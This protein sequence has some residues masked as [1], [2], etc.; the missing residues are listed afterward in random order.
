MEHTPPPAADAIFVFFR[1]ETLL[2]QP[3]GFSE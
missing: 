2:F 3:H 1:I